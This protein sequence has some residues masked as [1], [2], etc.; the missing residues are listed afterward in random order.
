MPSLPRQLSRLA[1]DAFAAAGLDAAYGTVTVS[2]RPDL[3]QFQCNG[4]LAAAKAA[5]QPPRAIAERVLNELSGQDIFRDLSLAGPGFI[6]ISLSDAFLAGQVQA[7]VGDARLGVSAAAEPQT[8]LLDFGGPNIAKPMHV[9][10][11]RA[12][13][14]GDSLQRL[15][16]FA[17]HKTVSDVHMGDWGL[18]MGMLISEIAQRHPDL[19][20]F[21]E[22]FTGPYP[23]DSPVS[24]ADLEEMYPTA[25]KACKADEARMRK[26][27][28]ATAALQTGR[29]GYIALW[30]HFMDVSV[31]GMKREFGALGVAFDLW[32]GEA[33][34][35]PFMPAM[36]ADMKTR[37]IAHESEGAWVIPVEKNDDKAEVPPL[38]LQKSDGSALYSTTDLA[39]IV[40]R[41]KTH[42]PDLM[43][44]VVDQRQHLH[45]EQVF[46]AAHKAGIAGHA[47]LE[48]VGFGTMNGTDGKPF[49]TREGGV[50]KLHDLIQMATDKARERMDEAGLAGE[51][52]PEERDRTAAQVGIAALKFA[53]LSNH[54]LSNYIF[55]LDRFT[56]FEGKTGP[57]LQYAA[58]RI[59]SIFRKAELEPSAMAGPVRIDSAVE[60]DL[61]LLL[62]GLEPAIEQAVER[63]APNVL[64]DYAYNLAQGF[65]RFYAEHHILSEADEAVRTSRLTLAALSLGV[66]ERVL[67]LLG[68][69]VPDRM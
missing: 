25:A 45:F 38:I 36:I 50:L 66:L 13:I 54:R 3:A 39:T 26:A 49:K 35:E 41:V 18:P 56:S 69:D 44:Y 60:R 24:M 52:A 53:D 58:V 43:L 1:G 63:R 20:Y 10:H 59:K 5:K 19:P 7:M 48:H 15:F 64:C 61:A 6:N 22:A 23:D 46:R 32:K 37:A 16:G 57:Y 51:L 67:G 34:A 8:V 31:A 17:G 65:S 11:L 68:I 14:I 47:A 42:D 2:D 40:D 27:R 28:A 30:R 9:G 4:A 21:D 33:D 12:T 29:P 55:D 62:T